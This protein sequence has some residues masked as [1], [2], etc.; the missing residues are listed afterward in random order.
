MHEPAD[1]LYQQ[2]LNFREWCPPS[3][4]AGTVRSGTRADLAGRCHP[5]GA[6]LR[7]LPR[8]GVHRAPTRYLQAARPA[9]RLPHG[10]A[11]RLAD[12]AA[13]RSGA[14]LLDQ[15]RLPARCPGCRSRRH[16]SVVPAAAS[17]A[18]GR[19]DGPATLAAAWKRPEKPREAGSHLPTYR[20]C[21]T[22]YRKNQS[23][24]PT[25]IRVPFLNATCGAGLK[26]LNRLGRGPSARNAACVFTPGNAP[27]ARRVRQGWWR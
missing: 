16:P 26:A 5:P 7:A 9:A 4:D 8:A 3:R 15:R 20:D 17:T 23:T 24:Q 11:R 18:A 27:A 2:L 25:L 1:C 19:R 12:G 21:Q 22:T 13:A 6:G 14:G 10:P